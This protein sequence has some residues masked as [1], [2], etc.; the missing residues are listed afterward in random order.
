MA[1]GRASLGAD[2]AAVCKQQGEFPYLEKLLKTGTRGEVEDFLKI[3]GAPKKIAERILQH[4]DLRTL[5]PEPICIPN[6][7][8]DKVK[9]AWTLLYTWG[10]IDNNKYQEV[11]TKSDIIALILSG[12]GSEKAQ[13]TILDLFK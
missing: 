7:E 11:P 12:V 10:Y 13:N 8:K 3:I 9:L 5:K 1:G 2:M 6:L 4:F